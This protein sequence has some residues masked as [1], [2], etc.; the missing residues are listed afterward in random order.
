MVFPRAENKRTEMFGKQE[1]KA[2]KVF[3]IIGFGQYEGLVC[4]Y[5][6]IC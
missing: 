6:I 2:T 5:Y 1:Q 3:N 4:F